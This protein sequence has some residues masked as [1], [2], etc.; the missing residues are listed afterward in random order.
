[1]TLATL[2]LAAAAVPDAA[3]LDLLGARALALEKFADASRVTVDIVTDK[4]DANGAV[5]KSTHLALRVGRKNGEVDRKLLTYVVDGEDLTEAKRAEQEKPPKKGSLAVKSPFHPDERAKYRF[6]VLAPP[7]D[8]P[9][10]MRLGFQ[11]AGDKKPELYMGDAT[12][13]PQTGDVHTLSL[14]LSKTPV[15]VDSLSIEAT[16]GAQ[17]PAG[18]AMSRLAI[19]GVAGALFFKERFQVVTTFTDYE[20][21]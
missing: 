7:A 19:K 11:P 15:F 12:V 13:D 1:M 18:R 10:L 4:L 14:R 20:P 5:K 16:L 2:I 8:Q 17:T 3:L 6:A 9:T 21:L